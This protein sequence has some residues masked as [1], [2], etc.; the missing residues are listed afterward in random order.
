VFKS[1]YWTHMA[2]I[3]HPERILMIFDGWSDAQG[4]APAVYLTGTPQLSPVTL[5]ICPTCASALSFSYPFSMSSPISVLPGASSYRQANFEGMPNV[6]CRQCLATTEICSWQASMQ[7]R[8]QSQH[9][10][11]VATF[12]RRL[13]LTGCK[14]CER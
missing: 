13:T 2:C 14:R 8:V 7:A 3:C 11:I 12:H 6:P 10:V 1:A 4:S 5:P 9:R